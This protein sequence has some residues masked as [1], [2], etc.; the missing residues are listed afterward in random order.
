MKIWAIVALHFFKIA[1]AGP[2]WLKFIDFEQD[3]HEYA[4]ITKETTVANE[5][6]DMEEIEGDIVPRWLIS[7]EKEDDNDN[8]LLNDIHIEIDGETEIGYTWWMNS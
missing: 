1:L 2:W 7:D 6:E 4:S 3:Q 5:N 8:S